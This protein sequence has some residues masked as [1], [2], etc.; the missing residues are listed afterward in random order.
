MGLDDLEKD[1]D[2]FTE[3]TRSRLREIKKELDMMLLTTN[4]FF[5]NIED[6]LTETPTAEVDGRCDEIAKKIGCLNLTIEGMSDEL[7]SIE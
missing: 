3:N 7:M 5:D 2:V 4:R 6:I 1:V